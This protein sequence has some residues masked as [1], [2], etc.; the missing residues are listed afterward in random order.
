MWTERRAGRGCGSQGPCKD[1]QKVRGSCRC[2]AVHAGPRCHTCAR[3]W[4]ERT[5]TRSRERVAVGQYDLAPGDLAALRA[6]QGGFCAILGC[7][8]QGKTRDLTIDHDHE[9]NEVR[10]LLCNTHNEMLGRA[11]DDP[12]VFISLALYLLEPPARSV[13]TIKQFDNQGKP[14]ILTYYDLYVRSWRESLLRAVEHARTMSKV[15]GE[16]FGILSR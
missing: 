5:K 9:D 1:C 10:G 12:A 7:R 15:S 2:V 14:V 4:K 16:T 6:N 3:L 13:L 8:A 11:G